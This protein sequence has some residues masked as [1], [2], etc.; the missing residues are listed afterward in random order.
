MRY[1]EAAAADETPLRVR[2]FL[3]VRFVCVSNCVAMT[4]PQAG[5]GS[6][7]VTV[8]R[9]RLRHQPEDEDGPGG[10]GR[11]RMHMLLLH[12]ILRICDSTGVVRATS[13]P[14]PCA[15]LRA[16]TLGPA[17]ND[18]QSCRSET[19]NIMYPPQ[20]SACAARLPQRADVL[21]ARRLRVLPVVPAAEVEVPRAHHPPSAGPGDRALPNP[22]PPPVRTTSGRFGYLAGTVQLP[23]RLCARLQSP[24][25]H[26]SVL[27]A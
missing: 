16:T 10:P 15:I 19:C 3:R 2:F 8:V 1:N 25:D 13:L 24:Y 26:V 14:F 7:A 21:Q 9:L 20:L 11:T 23:L 12:Q 22:P 5:A 17:V 18:C 6:A 27:T 4:Q